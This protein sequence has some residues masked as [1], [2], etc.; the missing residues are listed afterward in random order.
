MRP[1]TSGMVMRCIGSK[2]MKR[3]A[4]NAGW[5]V[6][7]NTA[8]GSTA[9]RVTS[10]TPCSFTPRS[11]ALPRS[12]AVRGPQLAPQQPPP[13]AYELVGALLEAVE[14]QVDV[15]LEFGQPGEET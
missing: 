4:W 6:T 8:G 10:P 11:S 15:R 7:P 14:L 12:H 2:G 1:S 9:K 13:A 3:P 5:M